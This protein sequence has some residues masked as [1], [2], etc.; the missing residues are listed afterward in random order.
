MTEWEPALVVV[1]GHPASGKTTVAKTLGAVLGIP[2]VAKDDI[3]E[4][5]FDVLGV[6]DLDW[7]HRL[8]LASMRLL[9]QHAENLLRV[10]LP[11]I[12]EAPFERELATADL[13]AILDAVG[14]P[15]ILV[16]LE[17]HGPDLVERYEARERDGDRHPGHVGD[18]ETEDLAA[19][20]LEPYEPPDLPGPVVPVDCSDPE[21]VDMDKLA[22]A[23]RALIPHR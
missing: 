12:V 19:R 9:Y 3:K 16:V 5:L 11:V 2:V 21:H 18:V 20:L 22:A 4:L 8:G 10:G 13:R 17:A 1:G 15:T 23:V 7:S 6:G 14:V